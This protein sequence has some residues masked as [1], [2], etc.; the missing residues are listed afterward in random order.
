ME[1][2]KWTLFPSNRRE[3]D[4]VKIGAWTAHANI[5]EGKIS[6]EVDSGVWVLELVTVS[7]LQPEKDPRIEVVS[8]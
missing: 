2:V 3:G 6:H 5:S 4:V 8:W 7:K 1:R